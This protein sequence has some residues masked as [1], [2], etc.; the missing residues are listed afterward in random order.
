LCAKWPVDELAHMLETQREADGP[1]RRHKLLLRKDGLVLSAPSSGGDIVFKQNLLAAGSDAAAEAA[2]GNNG[3]ML[4]KDEHGAPSLVGFAASHGYRS[5]PGLGW[6][7]LVEQDAKIAFASTERL[8]LLTVGLGA[9]VAFLVSL[10]SIGISRR[11]AEPILKV[12]AVASQ[13]AE[14]NFD[15]RVGHASR[16]KDDEIGSL[17]RV[18]DK[19]IEDLKSKRA[20]LV[21]KEHVDSL[22]RSIV[23]MLVVL[24]R[25]GRIRTLNRPA[26]GL[27]GWSEIELTGQSAG[28]L[29]D[30]S[31]EQYRAWIETVLAS[32]RAGSPE[33]NFVTRDKRRIPVSVSSSVMRDRDGEPAGIVC[34]ARD[35]T[36]QHA[37][38]EALL[39]GKEAAEEAN[40]VK[41][42]FLANMSHELRTPLN[43]IIGY[44]ELLQD[45]ATELGQPDMI[46]DLTK[47]HGAGKHLLA[48]INDILDL[49]KIEAGKMDLFLERFEVRPLIEE[50]RATILP[51]V[52]KN[53][54]VLELQLAP[55]V[56]HMH[57]DVTRVRQI[58]FNLLSNAC[59]FTDHGAV[60]LSVER[61]RRS[62]GD[63]I[64][65]RVADSGI[66]MTPAQLGKLFQAF[67]QADSSTSRK[68]G[69]TGLGLVICR[70]FCQMMGGDVSVTSEP[71]KGS[72]FT[73]ELPAEAHKPAAPEA[74][75]PE[76]EAPAAEAPLPLRGTI[77]VVDDDPAASELLERAL[78][79]ERFRVVRAAGGEEGLRLARELRP[80]VMT[81]DVLMPGMDGWTVLREMKRDPALAVIPVIVVTMTDDRSLAFSLGASDFVRKPIDR[82]RLASVLKRFEENGRA[83]SVLIVDDDPAVRELMSRSLAGVGWS[84]TDAANGRMA[85]ERLEQAVPDLIVLD[86]MMPEM[87]GFEMLARLQQR[88]AWS[89]IPVVVVTARDVTPEILLRLGA[90]VRKVFHKTSISRD[91]LVQEV[92]ALAPRSSA[93]V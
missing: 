5:F 1:S 24:D 36:D 8:K 56:G 72:V 70:R 59:K 77:L 7:V 21:D 55:D 47:I 16:G 86:L 40:R 26:Q 92:M 68:Y 38:Q 18:F 30:L 89:Q 60:S 51:L 71:G 33:L 10:A 74:A 45:E 64:V 80:F 53:S 19:M 23:D 83:G 62:G 20:Q 37:A 4:E 69:G 67:T 84:V 81:L 32:G 39:Q 3:S 49:S 9:L 65:I 34:I 50:V 22:I 29:F 43:A 12:S 44:S 42:H 58:L 6:S 13:V 93:A 79:K 75:A 54:N 41:S 48:L 11:I 57:G 27:L 17:A 28:V 52:E 35:V 31:E 63:W 15:V 85:L 82:D 14:G 2:R 78:S 90:N 76:P 46:P 73:V 88:E 91:D 25:D 66:G 61:Q 87:D